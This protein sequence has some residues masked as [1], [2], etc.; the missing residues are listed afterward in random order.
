MTRHQTTDPRSFEEADAVLGAHGMTKV[1]NNTY[2]ARRGPDRIAVTLHGNDV[3]TFDRD[4]SFRADDCGWATVTT[5]DRLNRYT[6]AG[7]RF[8]RRKGVTTMTVGDDF[9]HTTALP[10]TVVPSELAR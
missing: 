8:S 1:A 7:Y 5:A 4:G 3:V 10:V 9:I 6:P 2:L